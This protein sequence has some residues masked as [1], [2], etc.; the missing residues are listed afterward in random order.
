MACRSEVNLGGAYDIGLVLSVMGHLATY[1]SDKPPARSSERRKIATR[2]TVVHGLEQIL[3]CIK[4]PEDDASLDFQAT[5][6][7]RKLDRRKRERRR[8]R[9]DRPAGERRLDQDRQPARRAQRNREVLGCGRAAPTHARR[10]SAAP[11][12]HSADFQGD[13]P[14]HAGARPP[15]VVVRRDAG[16]ASRRCCCRRRPTRTA[17]FRC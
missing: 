3:R 13:H 5:L 16:Q 6:R 17:T 10:V 1:W 4:P 9:R 2:L 8:F 11:R 12:R 14:R 7:R 15:C